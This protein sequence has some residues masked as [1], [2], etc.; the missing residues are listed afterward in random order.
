[1]IQY[2]DSSNTSS[3]D[4][5]S[6]TRSPQISSCSIL[7]W[8]SPASSSAGSGHEAARQLATQSPLLVL[9]YSLLHSLGLRL[10]FPTVDIGFQHFHSFRQFPGIGQ[11]VIGLLVNRK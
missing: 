4:F 10:R 8:A 6:S 1:M 7:A 5:A 2:S 11:R 3:I 9:Q